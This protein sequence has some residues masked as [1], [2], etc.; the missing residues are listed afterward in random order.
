MKK[1]KVIKKVLVSI[2]KSYIIKS[3]KVL[4]GNK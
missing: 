4:E 3:V 1:Y 2:K